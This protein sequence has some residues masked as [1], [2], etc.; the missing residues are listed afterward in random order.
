MASPFRMRKCAARWSA[1]SAPDDCSLVARSCRR[2][3]GYCWLHTERKSFCIGT[4]CQHY[5]RQYQLVGLV[6]S[7]W[8]SGENQRYSGT[9]VDPTSVR[10]SVSGEIGGC[11]NCARAARLATL[12]IVPHQQQDRIDCPARNFS[13]RVRDRWKQFA[14]S[15]FPLCLISV[16]VLVTPRRESLLQNDLFL[17]HQ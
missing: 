14:C 10:R 13:A 16:S 15:V 6:P 2:F 8:A 1:F 5:L 7:S 3:R 4:G 17:K 12:A 11:R 9:R